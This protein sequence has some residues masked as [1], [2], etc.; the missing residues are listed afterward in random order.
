VAA[1][2][3]PTHM[4]AGARAHRARRSRSR[5]ARSCAR[6]LPRSRIGEVVRDPHHAAARAPGTAT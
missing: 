2:E 6:A 4:R 5:R 1:L 3:Q